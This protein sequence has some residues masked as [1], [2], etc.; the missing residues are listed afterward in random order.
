MGDPI[1]LGV[2]ADTHRVAWALVRMVGDEMLVH[3]VG[4]VERSN[5]RKRMRGGYDSGLDAIPWGLATA[6]YVER[7]YL[8]DVNGVTIP[9]NVE[10]FG[11][12]SE[13]L[14]EVCAA[15]RR[16]G[17]VARRVEA[18][19]WQEA[20]LG[21]SKG[22]TKLKE[23]MMVLAQPMYPWRPLTEHEGDAIGVAKFGLGELLAESTAS[24]DSTD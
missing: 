21:L 22:R 24:T 3:E 10:M 2:D 13:I 15:A 9:Q 8:S 17:K 19:D 18:K 1:V 23:A 5:S 20:V 6:V 4:T 11:R 14:G 12:L 7:P 16:G